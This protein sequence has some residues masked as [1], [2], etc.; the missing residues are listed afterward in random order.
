M[1]PVISRNF[2]HSFTKGRSSDSSFFVSF[3]LPGFPVAADKQTD[4]V[5]SS[6]ANSTLTAAGPYENLTHFPIILWRIQAPSAIIFS[7]GVYVFLVSAITIDALP[8]CHV[9]ITLF[10]AYHAITEMSRNFSK[11]FPIHLVKYQNTDFWSS[12]HFSEIPHLRLVKYQNTDFRSSG[13]PQAARQNL[14][15]PSSLLP[16]TSLPSLLP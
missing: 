8:H 13:H 7:S 14:K 9:T 3:R 11:I 6:E 15:P 10:Q 5:C 2:V 12:G 16:R 1:Q 4:L